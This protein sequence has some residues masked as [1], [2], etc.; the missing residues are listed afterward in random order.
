MRHLIRF[1]FLALC[2][3][4]I[5]LAGCGSSG[6]S[7]TGPNQATVQFTGPGVGIP[8][9]VIA[10]RVTGNAAATV[11]VPGA[12]VTVTAVQVTGQRNEGD[13]R[14]Q[15]AGEVVGTTI[16]DANGDFAVTVPTGTHDI[17]I[18]APGFV[19][20]LLP[21]VEVVA[22]RRTTLEP[23]SIRLTAAP[24]T[25]TGVISGV[26]LNEFDRTPFAGGMVELRDGTNAVVD[27]AEVNPFGSFQFVN[28]APGTY[29]LT[30]IAPPGS[31]R[32]LA[33]RV[34]GPFNVVAGGE[35]L[36]PYENIF[37]LGQGWLI[38]VNF[39]GIQRDYD[40][41]TFAPLAQPFHINFRQLGSNTACPFIRLNADDITG[42]GTELT[43]VVDPDPNDDTVSPFPGTYHFGVDD[44][45]NTGNNIFNT[46]G[47]TV[48]V[49]TDT[50]TT[51]FTAPQ[52]TGLYWDVARITWD[53]ANLT[54]APAPGGANGMIIADEAA[55][56]ANVGYAV[57]ESSGCP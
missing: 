13:V 30:S 38:R 32:A 21:N 51:T 57:D 17:M 28:V 4:S 50:M 35:I 37:T 18:N 47:V 33:A 55:A 16:T 8:Q 24:G 6:G 10:G 14:A 12:T 41:H 44:F 52:G 19:T 36:A 1:S 46:E 45:S 53:G 23:N 54:I 40:S 25:T 15:R 49:V 26:L 43:E 27:T 7:N 42:G 34:F 48:D 22:D 39:V 56:A 11:P 2:I 5:C 9:G 20:R 3:A 31:P 29:T